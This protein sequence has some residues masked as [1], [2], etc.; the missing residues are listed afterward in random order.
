MLRDDDR[1][2]GSI[3]ALQGALRSLT[4]KSLAITN[5]L[6]A[7]GRSC[8]RG[9]ARGMKGPTGLSAIASRGYG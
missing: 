8:L 7:S 4:Q 6:L 5:V 9:F 2:G 3:V 1:A